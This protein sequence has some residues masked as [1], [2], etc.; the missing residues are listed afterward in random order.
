[1][2]NFVKDREKVKTFQKME[3]SFLSSALDWQMLVDIGGQLKFPVKII[4][5]KLRPEMTKRIIMLELTVPWEGN[6]NEGH[7]KK[8]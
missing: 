4:H 8:K 2:M 5:T 7:D 3:T 6:M 1:M